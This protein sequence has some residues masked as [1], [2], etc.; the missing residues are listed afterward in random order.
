L[1]AGCPGSQLVEIQL[2]EIDL[3]E[4]KGA[5]YVVVLRYDYEA[6]AMEVYRV[7]KERMTTGL[8]FFLRA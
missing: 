1:N 8:G 5:R 2:K 7:G 6:L 3:P 4:I